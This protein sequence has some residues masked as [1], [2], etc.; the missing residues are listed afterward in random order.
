MVFQDPQSSLNPRQTAGTILSAP[1]QV[2][3]VQPSGAGDKTRC[4]EETPALL[5][6]SPGQSAACHFV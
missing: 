2:Q 6:L 5:P 4:A 1:L 3:G